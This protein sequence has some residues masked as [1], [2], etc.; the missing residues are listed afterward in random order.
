MKPTTHI[1]AKFE[2]TGHPE[3]TEI[4][5]SAPMY[6][7]AK[8]M[9]EW[10]L[11][12]RL[13]HKIEI[14]FAKTIEQL[15]TKAAAKRN[16]MAGLLEILMNGEDTSG[17]ANDESELQGVVNSHHTQEPSESQTAETET[18]AKPA[19]LEMPQFRVI[20]KSDSNQ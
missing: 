4:H 7:Q 1:A 13:T 14:R 10:L 9:V 15:E 20:P 8:R 3:L 16:E 11:R 6:E 18:S 19:G 17:D 12:A 5:D 2:A